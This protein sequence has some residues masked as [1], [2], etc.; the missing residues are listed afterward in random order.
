MARRI[1]PLNPLRVFEVVARTQ[2]L[3]TA[4]LEL[5][6]TQS[7]V[8]RQIAVLEAY[9][10]KKLFRRGPHGVTLTRV[11]IAYAEQIIPAFEDIARATENLAKNEDSVRVR[12]HTSF[13]AKWLIPHLRDFEQLHPHVKVHVITVLPDVDYDYDREPV[14][15]SILQGTGQWPRVQAEFLFRDE[16]EP[17]CAPAYLERIAGAARSPEKLLGH[18]LLVSRNRRRDWD[19]WLAAAGLAAH[20]ASAEREVYGISV[21]TWQAA[22]DGLGIAMGQLPHL[23][24]EVQSGALVRPFGLAVPRGTA[25]YIVGSSMER[26]TR[27]ARVF[28]DWLLEAVRGDVPDSA[29]AAPGAPAE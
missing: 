2:N 14:D 9:L 6:V 28:R 18:R 11:G 8:S 20:A 1:P 16:I 22:I 21:L 15:M 24:R 23:A 27:P 29:R 4:A 13:A 3:T 25:H 7:A 10:D 26:E 12:T 19:E 17:V 5:H